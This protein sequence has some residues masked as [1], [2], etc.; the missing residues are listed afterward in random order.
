MYP[1]CTLTTKKISLY[2][3]MSNVT[4]IALAAVLSLSIIFLVVKMK[5]VLIF[6]RELIELTNQ[7]LFVAILTVMPEIG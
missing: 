5:F 4:Q 3:Y 7:V 1:P 6:V 2:I